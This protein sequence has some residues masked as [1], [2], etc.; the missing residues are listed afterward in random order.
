[1]ETRQFQINGMTCASCAARLEKVMARKEGV[2]EA[3]V[4]FATEQLR[5][6]YDENILST[7]EILHAVEGA[8]FLA[9][10][11]H[12]PEQAVIEIGGMTCA[13][14]AARLEKVLG[15]TEGVEAA[16]VNFATS[17]ATLAFAPG[18]IAIPQIEQIIRDAG[19]EPKT[20]EAELA[21]ESKPVALIVAALLT[22]PVF[23]ISMIPG[24]AFPGSV[25]LLLFL[26]TIVLFW[27]GWGILTGAWKAMRHRSPNMDVLIAMGTLS[28]YFYSVYLTYFHGGMHT[29]FE[30]SAVIIT[31][32]LLG[33]YLE[34]R[35]KGRA[36]AAIK[37]LIGL[38]P[39]T[40]RVLVGDDVEE[41]PVETLAVGDKIQ[42]RPGERI[43]T[44]GI[45]LTG[46]S[47]LDES[48][49][50]G[51]PIPVEKSQGDPVIGGTLNQSGG[52]TFE[53][54][55]VGA[56]TVLAQVIG[57]VE[58]A[59]GRKAPIQRLADQVSAVFVPIVT[60]I[61]LLTFLGWL[62]LTRDWGMAVSSAVA[63]LVIACPCAMGL[64]TPTAIMVGTGRGASHGI[65]IR[66][67][68]ILEQTQ[69]LTSVIFD[70]TGTLTEG[71]P[72]LQR[73]LPLENITEQELLRVVAAAEK[74]SE[75][76]LGEAIVR[77]ATELSLPDVT[78]FQAV[79]GAGV[80]A[81]VEGKQVLV[82]TRR[83]MESHGISYLPI[84][85]LAE[86]LEGDGHTVMFAAI[87]GELRGLLSVADTVKPHAAEAVELLLKQG[88]ELLMITGDNR[89]TAEAIARS[90]GI[91]VVLP[92]VLPQEKSQ[93]VKRLQAQGKVVGMVGDGINDAPALA[94]AD[95][96]ISLGTGTDIAIEAS[97]LTLVSGDVRGVAAAIAL[98]RAT[99][100][101]IK[102]N[103]FW[104]FFYNILGIPIAAL[105][106]LNPMIAAGAM[107]FSSIFVLTNSLRLSRFRF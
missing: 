36:S 35:A 80:Q 40:A 25:Y 32:I 13:S 90:V 16:T 18:K 38:R 70:K 104:A 74:G 85:A 87:D 50:T 82:G 2:H 11:A 22:L 3:V 107:A 102:Q 49:L 4:N 99:L 60:A 7:E 27:S 98:S 106:F 76:P 54:T 59:Q 81:T 64:A 39:K 8:G 20:V 47:T 89:R 73:V 103:L 17:K 105:G 6:T 97:D 51:E 26:T 30:T 57:L 12:G 33:R 68:E 29:Y 67:G 45:I 28:A 101:I 9:V 79:P 21:S 15:R 91:K 24:L 88:L 37:G 5:I 94:Q 31:L 41:R 1:M 77:G 14:C 62:I 84:S 95:I 48:M 55:K 75:H 93:E 56:D 23:L 53:A 78:D 42:V 10:E 86:D 83:L 61:A 96:G 63:V 44:D 69:R 66:G 19:F 71:K 52:F 43:P 46:R 100:R 58:E 72:S 92:E 34:E 65:L